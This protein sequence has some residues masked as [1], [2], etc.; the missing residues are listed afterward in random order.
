MNKLVSIWAVYEKDKFV[1]A[2][3]RELL[4]KIYVSN[5]SDTK[6]ITIKEL[7]VKEKEK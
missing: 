6:N 4:C 5:Y 2:Y 3:P 1:I 7:F